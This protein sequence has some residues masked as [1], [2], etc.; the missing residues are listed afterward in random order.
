MPR[1]VARFYITFTEN[2]I[3]SS[4]SI[5]N[6]ECRLLYKYAADDR[7]HGYDDFYR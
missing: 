6:L 5:S 1:F 3:V 2:S 7:H 4:V